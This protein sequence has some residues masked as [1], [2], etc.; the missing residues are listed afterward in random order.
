[1]VKN[2]LMC[3]VIYFAF[4][5]MVF[6][7]DIDTVTTDMLMYIHDN[8]PERKLSPYTKWLST[9]DVDVPDI[10][11]VPAADMTDVF[12]AL[13]YANE[14]E[15]QD[16]DVSVGA[17]YNHITQTMYFKDTL[18]VTS[19]LGQSIVLHELIHHVQ[20]INGLNFNTCDS[21]RFQERQAY[22]MQIDFMLAN[23]YSQDDHMITGLKWNKLFF[24]RSCVNPHS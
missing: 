14:S 22:A 3:V 1:M 18:D 12:R 4:A 15:F 10:V 5:S 24:G 6:A 17:F 9:D 11:I 7:S 8:S 21:A 23:G 2:M 16:T 13:S 20:L 19:V